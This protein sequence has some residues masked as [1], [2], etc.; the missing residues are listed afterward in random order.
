MILH[1]NFGGGGAQPP[2]SKYT[3]Y[4][5]AY[6]IGLDK[7]SSV[8]LYYSLIQNQIVQFENLLESGLAEICQIC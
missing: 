8:A 7:S 5:T 4:A 6:K 1:T 3:G 2:K